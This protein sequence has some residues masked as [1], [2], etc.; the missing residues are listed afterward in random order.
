M[1]DLL[2]LHLSVLGA[3]KQQGSKAS[4]RRIKSCVIYC[5]SDYAK[6][7]NDE[8]YN[9]V[10]ERKCKGLPTGHF[11]VGNYQLH[12]TIGVTLLRRISVV[13]G[14]ADRFVDLAVLTCIPVCVKILR[15]RGVCSS[16]GAT[17]ESREPSSKK[18][19]G[20]RQASTHDGDLAFDNGPIDEGVETLGL[21]IAP[22]IVPEDDESDNGN[23]GKA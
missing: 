7:L 12:I 20:S 19:P 5:K 15:P 14:V 9:E 17:H 23:D 4:E 1:I 21:V 3:E 10:E 16:R 13:H 2:L 11:S 8:L 22:A 6:V 18:S